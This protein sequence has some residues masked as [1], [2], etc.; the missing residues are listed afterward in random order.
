MR[1]LS[2][3]FVVGF[4]GSALAQG[5]INGEGQRSG[6]SGSEAGGQTN[7][8]RSTAPNVEGPGNG[9]GQTGSLGGNTS[10]SGGTVTGGAAPM[11][12]GSAKGTGPLQGD[13]AAGGQPAK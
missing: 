6:V 4:A 3:V 8:T 11:G 2:L 12:G 10:T 7:V 13:P 1:F 9:A 5:A